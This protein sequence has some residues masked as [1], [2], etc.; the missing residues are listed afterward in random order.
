MEMYEVHLERKHSSVNQLAATHF[1][2]IYWVHDYQYNSYSKL[3]LNR[4]K[5]SHT[6]KRFLNENKR[7]ASPINGFDLLSSMGGVKW[8]ETTDC[9]SMI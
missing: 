2:L 4:H 5:M 9:F 8:G 6:Q 7:L 3:Y 1:E